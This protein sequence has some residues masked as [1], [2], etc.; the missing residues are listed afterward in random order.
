MSLF[1]RNVSPE[2][3][4]AVWAQRDQFLENG[5]LRRQTLVTTLFSDLEG[6]TPLA[7]NMEPH[8]LSDWLSIYLETTVTIIAAHGGRVADYY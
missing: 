1:S 6:F 2:T 7:E 4:Q 8:K 3:A 5:H